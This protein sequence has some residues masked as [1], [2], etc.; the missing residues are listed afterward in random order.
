[1]QL[2][3][4]RYSI[5]QIHAVIGGYAKRVP[6]AAIAAKIETYD[7]RAATFTTK[8]EI[9][10][11]D[12]SLFRAA[13][14]ALKDFLP[15]A[16]IQ[17]R[18][19]GITICGMDRSHVGFVHYQLAKADCKSL[20]IPVP[21]T[22]GMSLINLSR[23]LANVGA[24]D[25][26]RLSLNKTGDRLV[27]NYTN[28]RIGK[29]AV[30]EIP[31]LEIIEDAAELPDLTYAAKISAK[32]S[33]IVGVIKE[34]GAFGDSVT[35]TLNEHGFHIDATGDMGSAKQTLENTDDRDMELTEDSV[36]ATY[37][38]KYISGIMKGC[39]P[40]SSTTILEFDSSAQPLRVSFNYGTASHFMAY[41]APKIVD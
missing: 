13:I 16:Q 34:V 18:S 15:E 25:S 11:N 35:L 37:A 8:M 41:L 28:E 9:I 26:L 36:T 1:M 40:L 14:D 4:K 22:I 3:T 10:P 39:A 33:D 12:S 31:M 32:T 24:G 27:V 5:A 7:N 19:T 17:V 29:K 21:Q 20:K 30:Y 2:K 6:R 23:V 38:T